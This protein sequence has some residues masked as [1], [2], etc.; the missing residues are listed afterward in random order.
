MKA[1]SEGRSTN[2]SAHAPRLVPAGKR[3]TDQGRFL[4][5]QS[6]DVAL[7]LR[8]QCR[9]FTGFP[10]NRPRRADEGPWAAPWSTLLLGAALSPCQIESDGASLHRMSANRYRLLVI[11]A[12]I[13]AAAIMR[14]LPHPPNFTPMG[15]MAL[16]S[17]AYLERRWMAFAAPLGALLLSDLMLGFYPG[18]W[19]QYVATALAVALG[20]FALGQKRGSLRVGGTTLAASL[21]FFLVTNFGVWSLSSIYPHNAA[22]LVA[23]YTAALPFFQNSIAGDLFY[24]AAL[25]GGFAMLERLI[26]SVRDRRPVAA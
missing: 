18:M 2:A 13:A 6:L 25:F 26:P 24:A 4:T 19:V 16:F 21:M 22:G 1:V 7:Q 5:R 3:T 8:A 9:I 15:A 23:C 20:L 17:G 10:L 14:L 11:I 12:G